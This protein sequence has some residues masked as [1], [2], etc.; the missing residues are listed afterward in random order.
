VSDPSEHFVR[1]ELRHA[2]DSRDPDRTAMLNRIA[3]NRAA[4]TRPR[5]QALRLAGS[6]LAVTTVLG[7]GGVAKWALADERYE[8]EP[9]VAVATQP[10]MSLAPPEQTTIGT[11]GS[12]P[13]GRTTPPS[14][15]ASSSGAPSSPTPSGRVR[16]HPGDTQV[17]KG[18]LWSA[19]TLPAAGQTMVTLKAATDLTELTLDIRITPTD[20]LTSQGWST[21]VPGGA[22]AATVEEQAGTLVYHFELGA[23]LTL[24]A[25][26]YTFTARH[27]GDGR[28]PADDTYEAYGTSVEHKR[29]HIYGN[30]VPKE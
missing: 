19:G 7:L 20:G 21:N 11:P 13:P 2:L 1:S 16:G 12:A 14:T 29:I 10:V 9:P 24:K 6:A 27:G 22:V 15:A 8:N 17:E 18:T 26:T 25:G 3:A 5:G 30:F 23:G 4:G 28:D